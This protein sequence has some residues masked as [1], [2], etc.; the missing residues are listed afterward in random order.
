MTSEN[1]VRSKWILD[2][3][4]L[5]PWLLDEFPGAKLHCYYIPMNLHKMFYPLLYANKGL[6]GIFLS[7]QKLGK[8]TLL[9]TLRGAKYYLSPV[10]YGDFNQMSLQAKA[11]GCKVISYKGNP[12]ADYW[13]DEGDQRTMA[14]QL[15]AIMKGWTQPRFDIEPVPDT[16]QMVD[17]MLRV[18]KEVLGKSVTSE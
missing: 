3:L 10:R 1:S 12:Y 5:F 13:L 11:A 16:N 18:Y 8:D 6:R 17:G 4:L 14:L 15:L 2:L 7:D 9:A